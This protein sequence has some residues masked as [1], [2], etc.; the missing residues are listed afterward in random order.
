MARRMEK[1]PALGLASTSRRNTYRYHVVSLLI[2][3]A[4][5]APA[6]SVSTAKSAATTTAAS[7]AT[8]PK[9]TESSPQRLDN[10][11]II[12]RMDFKVGRLNSNRNTKENEDDD[13]NVHWEPDD[14]TDHPQDQPSV[15]SL[16]R[17]VDPD[18]I[19]Y[20]TIVGFFY[21]A[22]FTA[23]AVVIYKCC[24]SCLDRCGLC[25]DNE[26]MRK[27]RH[28]QRARGHHAEHEYAAVST[29]F[30]RD[31]HT[32]GGYRNEYGDCDG[33]SSGEESD[34][35]AE[36]GEVNNNNYDRRKGRKWDGGNDRFDDRHIGDAAKR[37]FDREEKID[38]QRQLRDKSRGGRDTRSNGTARSRNGDASRNRT[39]GVHRAISGGTG[40]IDGD[41]PA[42]LDLEM[43]ER[44]IVE[45]M[46]DGPEFAKPPRREG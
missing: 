7:I 23:I 15:F 30:Y 13:D 18:S 26:I 24:C 41:E 5:L 32:R 19:V 46:E 4:L 11:R 34:V 10:N 36:Y 40:V 27:R 39:G 17:Y 44:K 20:D 31:D 3:F 28:R 21:A 33:S 35:S 42:P 29:D 37:F 12:R 45:S 8:P 14:P 38:R 1:G 2:F 9:Y 16:S 22:I 43:I 6:C 25:P